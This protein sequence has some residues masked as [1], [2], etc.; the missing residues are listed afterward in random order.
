M[1]KVN[2]VYR[3]DWSVAR[4]YWFAYFDS[5]LQVHFAAGRTPTEAY[6]ALSNVGKECYPRFQL[7]PV[8]KRAK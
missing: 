2:L 5:G 1:N 6:K 7:P 3:R 8:H 4:S